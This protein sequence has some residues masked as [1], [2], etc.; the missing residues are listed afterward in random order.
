MDESVERARRRL[1]QRSGPALVLVVVTVAIWLITGADGHFWPV[2]V[3]LA[4][5]MVLAPDAW[6]AYGPGSRR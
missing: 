6:R 5:F 3:M 1:A 2:W 4:W